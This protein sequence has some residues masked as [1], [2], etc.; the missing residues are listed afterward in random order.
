MERMGKFIAFLS[1]VYAIGS[2]YSMYNYLFVTIKNHPYSGQIPWNQWLIIELFSIVPFAA[3]YVYLV[4]NPASSNSFRKLKENDAASVLDTNENY[5][6]ELF[7]KRQFL[8]LI[9]GAFTFMVGVKILLEL[10][11]EFAYLRDYESI[12]QLFSSLY[13]LFGIGSILF[14]YKTF[15]KRPF[16]ISI[17]G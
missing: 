16:N 13:F 12:D 14:V 2:A 7:S 11:D 8:K 5:E 15:N 9:T 10:F 3:I 6:V 4:F 17:V 1:V